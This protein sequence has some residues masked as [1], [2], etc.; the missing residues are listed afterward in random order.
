ML[1]SK[2]LIFQYFLKIIANKP[3][4]KK[5][6]KINTVSIVEALFYGIG[7]HVLQVGNLQALLIS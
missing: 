1:P 7:I 5:H 4:F 6:A 3:Q 2:L